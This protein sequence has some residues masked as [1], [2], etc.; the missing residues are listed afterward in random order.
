MHLELVATEL[1]SGTNQE[2]HAQGALL[3][4]VMI[5]ASCSVGPHHLVL[6]QDRA[7]CQHACYC[8]PSGWRNAT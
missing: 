3:Q 2:G 4:K 1:V 7:L 5:P 8:T 6:H